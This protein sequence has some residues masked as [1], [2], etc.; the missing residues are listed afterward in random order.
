[1]HSLDFGPPIQMASTCIQIKGDLTHLLAVCPMFEP[2]RQ[3]MR[4]LWR[5][6]TMSCLPLYTIIEK[7][8]CG[9]PEELVKFL[10][11]AETCPDILW[12]VQRMGSDVL[13]QV[14]YLT[15][16]WAFAIHRCRMQSIGCWPTG[17]TIPITQC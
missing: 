3:K 1:M 2:T 10:L 9:E 16:T 14:M 5:I 12:L 7:K 8:L 6:K 11:S 15:R 4:N 13:Q 17:H